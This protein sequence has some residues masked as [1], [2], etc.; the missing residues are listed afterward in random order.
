MSCHV[1]PVLCATHR[2]N[3][4]GDSRLPSKSCRRLECYWQTSAS[5]RVGSANKF[6][7]ITG[8]SHASVSKALRIVRNRYPGTTLSRPGKQ[9][10]DPMRKHYICIVHTDT[11]NVCIHTMVPVSM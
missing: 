5:P 2:L 9:A 4:V 11:G 8:I 1:L 3:Q 10:N 7:S 6:C